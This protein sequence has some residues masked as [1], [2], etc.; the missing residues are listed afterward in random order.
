M[1]GRLDELKEGVEALVNLR[2]SGAGE[3]TEVLVNRTQEKEVIDLK[4][5]TEAR[6]ST[7]ITDF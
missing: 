7:R 2:R 4:G 5:V 6:E 3:E 1:E